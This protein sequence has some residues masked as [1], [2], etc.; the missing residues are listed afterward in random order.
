MVG[1]AK[2]KTSDL[3]NGSTEGSAKKTV[4]LIN[5]STVDFSEKSEI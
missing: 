1:F 3:I 5:G 2:L 4:V